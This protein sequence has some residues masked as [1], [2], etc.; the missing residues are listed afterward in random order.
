M[1]ELEAGLRTQKK[2]LADLC[3]DTK[4]TPA[5]LRANLANVLQWAAYAA[6]VVKDV[7][8]QKYYT[9]FR[10]FFDRV[11]VARQPHRAEGGAEGQPE[12]AGGGARDCC[13]WRR[14]RRRQAGLRRGGQGTFPVSD[15]PARGRRL[16][17][18]RAIVG[19]DNSP[20]RRSRRRSARSAPWYR[21]TTGCI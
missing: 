21:P 4:Q 15:R 5:Q 20:G 2:T 3:R 7:D 18:F 10:D 8:L 16:A 11:T 12:R 6:K 14:D 9:T 17:A 1:A 13:N 19:E